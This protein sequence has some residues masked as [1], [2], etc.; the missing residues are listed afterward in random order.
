MRT[1]PTSLAIKSSPKQRVLIIHMIS[2]H[3]LEVLGVSVEG[4]RWKVPRTIKTVVAKSFST[5]TLCQALLTQTC[6]AGLSEKGMQTCK[7]CLAVDVGN[8][9]MRIMCNMERYL[10]KGIKES[11][12]WRRLFE[13][14]ALKT[15]FPWTS[16]RHGPLLL[17]PM[18]L[19]EKES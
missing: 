17:H 7:F 2:R 13:R 8:E 10:G 3:L 18:S 16:T 11:P 14:E 9:K 12:G 1:Q 5:F 19:T 6:K 15:D 4:D